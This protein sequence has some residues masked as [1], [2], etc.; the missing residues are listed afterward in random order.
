VADAQLIV[1]ANTFHDSRWSAHN[2]RFEQV[3]AGFELLSSWIDARFTYYYMVIRDMNIRLGGSGTTQ[4]TSK[5]T[6]SNTQTS[7]TDTETIGELPPPPEKEREEQAEP[8]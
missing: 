5:G 6:A 3:G 7:S 8:S 4:N 1:G 2:N